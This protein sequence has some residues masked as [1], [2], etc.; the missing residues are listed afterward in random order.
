MGFRFGRVPNL[1]R[2]AWWFLLA[3]ILPNMVF[4]LAAFLFGLGRP[5]INIDYAIVVA[6][7]ASSWRRLGVLLLLFFL[8]IDAL[9]LFVQVVPFVRLNDVFYIFS[10]AMLSSI[11]HVVWLCFFVLLYVSLVA[12]IYFVSCR[13]GAV[14][15]LGLLNVLFLVSLFQVDVP[16]AAPD[17]FYRVS[18]Q[19]WAKS[20]TQLFFQAR[21]DLFL[22][23][24]DEQGPALSPGRGVNASAPFWGGEG[25]D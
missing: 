3:L 1:V 5:Y 10:F 21:S 18:T 12:L 14:H 23:L 24:F 17:R 20:Q 13:A 7:L 11:Y 6:L 8:L 15:A 19:W 25:G 16:G 4:G 22:S 9:G 2:R